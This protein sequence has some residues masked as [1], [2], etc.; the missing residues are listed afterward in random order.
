MGWYIFKCLF[1]GNIVNFIINY[2]KQINKPTIFALYETDGDINY[3]NESKN[4][5]QKMIH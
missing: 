5:L 2:L 4:I 3:I 1:N